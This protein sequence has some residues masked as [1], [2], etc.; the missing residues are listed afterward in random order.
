MRQTLPQ[1][2]CYLNTKVEELAQREESFR[3]Y[4]GKQ[5]PDNSIG[6]EG[7]IYIMTTG[8]KVFVKEGDAWTLCGAMTIDCGTM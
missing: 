1:W 2:I 7:D 8:S 6:D 3:T 4:C 5:E